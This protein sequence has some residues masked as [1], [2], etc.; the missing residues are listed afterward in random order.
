MIVKGQK[1]LS[2]SREVVWSV[3]N[4]PAEMAKLMPGVESFEVQDE[5]HW[6]AKVKVPLGLGGL[7]MTINFERLEERPLEFASM[8][9]KGTGVGA[10]MDMTTSFTLSDAAS[11]TTMDWEADVRIAGPVGAM[12]QRVLQPIVNQQVS[13]VLAALERR[14]N[15]VAAARAPAA[16][17]AG[18]AGGAEGEPSTGGAAEG[19]HPASPEAYEPKPEGPT[20]STQGS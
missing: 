13:H 7:K 14:V 3:I 8:R 5:R 19:I 18:A 4:E 15:E 17:E 10:L 20:Q 16:S 11:G 1:E 9:A 2:A 12:G 6:T